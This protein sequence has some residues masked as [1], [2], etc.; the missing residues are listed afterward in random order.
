GKKVLFVRN[1]NGGIWTMNADGS[2][3]IQVTASGSGEFLPAWSPDGTKIAVERTVSQNSA[4]IVMNADGSNQVN[5]TTNTSIAEEEPK[6]SPDGTKIIFA[7]DSSDFIFVMNADG[8][9]RVRV[10]TVSAAREPVFSPDG[11][12]IAFHSLGGNFKIWVMN[13]NGTNVVQLTNQGNNGDD[14][15][16]CWSPDG[17]KIVFG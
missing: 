1:V 15:D 16:A 9:N 14:R 5:L 4:I 2:N 17:T 7:R 11:T 6:W 12:K 13:S 8:S 10:G 3:L